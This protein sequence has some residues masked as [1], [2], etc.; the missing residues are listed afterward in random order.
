VIEDRVVVAD[1]PGWRDERREAHHAPGLPFNDASGPTAAALR[2]VLDDV[3]AVAE[4]LKFPAVP[5]ILGRAAVISAAM[6]SACSRV[7]TSR[8]SRLG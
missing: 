5:G 7:I 2:G 3:P 4:L 6:R 1:D 8:P